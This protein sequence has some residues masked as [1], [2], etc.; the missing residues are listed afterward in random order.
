MAEPDGEAQPELDTL[1][2]QASTQR[3]SAYHNVVNFDVSKRDCLR[4]SY[5]HNQGW[6]GPSSYLFDERI[7]ASDIFESQAYTSLMQVGDNEAYVTCTHAS[8][9]HPL[10]AITK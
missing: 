8:N 7:N 9:P 6:T 1:F 5:A 3:G 4:F 2:T 10:L